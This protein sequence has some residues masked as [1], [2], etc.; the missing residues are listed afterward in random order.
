MNKI[1]RGTMT[2]VVILAG[3]TTA[4]AQG[5]PGGGGGP[6]AG[7]A[8][9]G[10]G[11]AGA[12]PGGGAGGP[13]GGGGGPGAGG[14]VVRAAPAAECA[15]VRAAVAGDRQPEALPSAADPRRAVPSGEDPP[16]VVGRRSVPVREAVR[17]V[18]VGPEPSAANGRVLPSEADPMA[19]AIGTAAPDLTAV[20]TGMAAPGRTDGPA[21][22]VPVPGADGMQARC[23]AAIPASNPPGAPSSGSRSCGAASRVS[24]A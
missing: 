2:A 10:G 24:T 17:M 8:G 15:A 23:A 7:G 12:G 5:G 18:P 20:L 19:G 11:A 16:S 4:F 3:A 22:A 6:G 9:A 14:P 21:S 1:L 13:G